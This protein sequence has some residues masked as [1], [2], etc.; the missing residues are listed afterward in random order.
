M[1]DDSAAEQGMGHSLAAAI[2]S[3][4]EA[5]G[6]LV[7][8]ADMPFIAPATISL[9]A[10]AL[11]GGASPSAPYYNGRR[12]HP[13]G[14][15]RSWFTHLNSLQ[16]DRE[17]REPLSSGDTALFQVPCDDAGILAESEVPAT[18]SCRGEHS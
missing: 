15:A 3:T 7:T 5:G 16:D 1:R 8:L 12:G 2:R 14:F 17:A 11:R 13:V 9:L 10:Y 6:W 4:P 18:L